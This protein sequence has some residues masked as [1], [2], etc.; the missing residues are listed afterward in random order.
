[1][2]SFR[3]F[4]FPLTISISSRLKPVPNPFIMTRWHTGVLC[5]GA[6]I[7]S[8]YV[9]VKSL[10][11]SVHLYLQW[12][13]KLELA[14]SLFTWP[15]IGVSFTFPCTPLVFLSEHRWL[16]QLLMSLDM[17]VK[18]TDS[19][20]ILKRLPWP[21]PDAWTCSKRAKQY[22]FLKQTATIL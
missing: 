4:F 7:G 14:L 9:F 1:M 21:G 5:Q 13:C 8:C 15:L 2:S 6:A 19:N 12:D 16:Q 20:W 11:P 3:L 22:F 17:W 18:Q 10:L